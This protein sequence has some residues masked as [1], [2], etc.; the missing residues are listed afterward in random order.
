M[1][2]PPSNI[3]FQLR[4]S[5]SSNWTSTNPILQAGEPGFESDTY[6]LK[7]GDG[8]TRWN[9]LPYI[10]GQVQQGA[11]GPQGLQGIQGPQGIQGLTGSTGPQG[12]QGIQGSA[13]QSF[14]LLGSYADITAFNA[15]KAAGL[16]NPYRQVG[17]AFILLSDGSLMTWSSTLNDWFDAG[18]IK[19]PQGVTGPQGIQGIQGI[20][21]PTGPQGI[22][23]IQGTQGI[24]GIQG[25]TGSTGPQGNTGPVSIPS[26]FSGS[27]GLARNLTTTFQEIS[28]INI[29]TQYT[30]YLWATV[31][32][33]FTSIDANADHQIYSKIE[34]DGTTSS[35]TRFTLNK[36][37][38]NSQ[39]YGQI[40]L[41]QRTDTIVSPGT[42]TVKVY[43][44]TDA[45]NSVQ[46]SH[47]DMFGMGHLS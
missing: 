21:G 5:I 4:R 42:Y 46:V 29:I 43:C 17:N 35:T 38:A 44:Y 11:T 33:G 13:G 31:S 19:G 36:K 7:I 8:I 41:N 10:S 3:K 6:K 47:C 1:A 27:S 22:Q 26:G 30:G 20:Q 40:S 32:L 9:L 18:D 28:S 37:T 15:A 23:G 45:N 39:S 34:I 16:L 25:N 14:T 2:C 24:Q 12:I